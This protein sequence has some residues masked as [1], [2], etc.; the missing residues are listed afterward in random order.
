M[1]IPG[2]EQA[3]DQLTV[4]G[5]WTYRWGHRRHPCVHPLRTPAGRVVTVDAPDDHPWHHGLWCTVKYVD[6]DN[7][8]EE[9]PPSGIQRHD[10]PPDV[11]EVRPGMVSVSGH[12]RWTRPDRTTVALDEE[13]RLTHVPLDADSYALDVVE[14]LI[15]REDT[16]FDRTPFTTWGGYGGLT[17]RGRADWIDT[18]L[19]LD[20]GGRR[21][22]VHGEHSRWCALA[23]TID[24]AP[25]GVVMMDHPSN[26]RHPTPWYAS[27]RSSTYGES[28][29]SNFL[30]AALLWSGPM[31]VRAGTALHLAYRVIVHDGWR[32]ADRITDDWE[33]WVA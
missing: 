22:V 24:G 8:W 13:R 14:M 3:D 2:V 23:G 12:L 17:L 18:S 19:V 29:W 5:A 31:S 30:N 1:Q 32:T 9:V 7:F 21:D 10:G 20:D 26:V 15:P 6:G 33:Q 11:T 4:A 16:T 28:G 25:V 27:T